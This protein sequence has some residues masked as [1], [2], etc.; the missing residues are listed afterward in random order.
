MALNKRLR[1][2]VDEAK[3]SDGYWV[4]NAKLGFALALEKWRRRSEM[5]NTELA[6]KVGSSPAYMTKVFRGDTNFTIETMVKLA[7]ACGGRLEIQIVETGVSSKTWANIARHAPAQHGKD[8]QRAQF[9]VLHSAITV[10]GTAANGDWLTAAAHD[11]R[12]ALAA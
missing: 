1:A 9:F 7:R 5:S 11:E 6:E 4:Q 10:P 2:L 3:K 12:Y 8:F